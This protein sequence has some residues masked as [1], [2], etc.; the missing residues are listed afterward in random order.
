MSNFRLAYKK[1]TSN[2]PQL[3]G[4]IL[5]LI[6]GAGFYIT[7]F[8][9]SMRYEETAEQYFIDHAYADIALQGAFNEES[10]QFV[11]EL[12][13]IVLAQGRNVRDFRE[14][15][16]IFRAISLTDS[17]NIPFIYD[18]RFPENE[19]EIMILNR[20]A[21]AMGFGLG[22]FLI[23]ENR[24]LEIVG[25]AAS[26]EYIYLVQ[27]EWNRMAQA[28]IFGVIFVTEN[29]FE[30]EQDKFNEIVILTHNADEIPVIEFAEIPGISR[31][32][33]QNEQANYNLFRDDLGQI[34]SFAL[35]FPLVFVI[36]IAVVIYVM[37]TRII[38]K[39]RKQIGIIKALG[40][41]DTKII[42][43]YLA[44]FCFAAPFG[45]LLGG[46]AAVFLTDFII[47]IFSSMFEVPMLGFVFYPNL[48]IIAVVISLLL[49]AASGLEPVH[50]TA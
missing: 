38:Q 2:I 20:N 25:L 23:I 48:W 39:D 49:C 46:V 16:R 33:M 19:S 41:S 47:D 45:V 18:G 43:I 17:I 34:R 1:A 12:D 28:G 42:G 35:I 14:N 8:T 24:N 30:F 31:I 32:I 15:E 44:Q 10:I 6:V 3:L 11:S 4:L 40:V 36:L 37:L 13:G 26:P 7:L 22:D 27:N 5:L 29:F 9:I 21:E 50:T